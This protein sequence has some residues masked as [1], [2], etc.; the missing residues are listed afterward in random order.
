MP[1]QS[2]FGSDVADLGLNISA[3]FGSE[4]SLCAAGV[5]QLRMRPNEN[6]VVG[7]AYFIASA[8]I[9]TV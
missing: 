3:A 1:I 2:V 9:G 8:V 4:I 5:W 7:V 6:K